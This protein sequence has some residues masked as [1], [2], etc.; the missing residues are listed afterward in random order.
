MQA[1]QMDEK[2]WAIAHD[3]AFNLVDRGTDPNE[4]GKIVAFIRRHQ[5]DDDAKN[6]L[7]SLLQRMADSRNA[8]IRSRQTQRFYQNIQDAC[9]EHLRD[10]NQPDELLLILGWSLRLMRYYR[11]EPQRASEEQRRSQEPK[12]TQKPRPTQTPQPTKPPEKP[13]VKVGDRVNATILKK[14]GSKVTVRLQTD[15]NELLVFERPYYPKKVGEK[16]KLRVHG[17]NESGQVT[18]IIP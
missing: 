13:K 2:R 9:Q 11:A 6:Q 17:V 16:I 8:L 5:G 3:I 12:Q 1:E 15:E 10:I 18:K 4:L 14:D 7:V